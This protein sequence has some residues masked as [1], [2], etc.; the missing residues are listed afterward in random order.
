MDPRIPGDF[1][2]TGTLPVAGRGA[3]P[4]TSGQEAAT[5][6]PE[7]I[8]ETRANLPLPGKYLAY[9]DSGR[10]IVVPVSRSGAARSGPG[11]PA[12]HSSP[13]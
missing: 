2:A 4:V 6:R 13:R 5:A 8:D 7:W 1:E 9:E 11:D 10:R 3:V 12:D